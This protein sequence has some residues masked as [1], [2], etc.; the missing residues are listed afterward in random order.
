[1]QPAPVKTPLITMPHRTGGILVKDETAQTT[2]AFKFRGVSAKLLQD[3]GTGPV[4]TAS[5]GN[6]GAAVAAV[7]EVQGR[8]AVVFV[9]ADTPTAKTRRIEEACA[10]LIRYEGDY[11]ACAAA[12]QDWARNNGA[13]YIPSFDDPM[14]IAGHSSAFREILEATDDL[15]YAWLP[16]G[17]GG[18]L[19]AAVT[20]LPSRTRVIGVELE[21]ADAMRQSLAA[22]R[23]LT[24]DVPR[25]VAEGLCVRQVGALPFRIASLARVPIVTVSVEQLEQAVR[26]LWF[27]AGIRAELA[28]AAAL[29]AAH[30]YIDHLPG[31]HVTVVS[32]GN[33]DAP[34]FD[35]IVGTTQA[36][37]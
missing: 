15:D 20:T 5:T 3:S 22:G 35:R 32:G 28:G 13:T 9:P 37:A 10:I 34:V 26:D 17:G 24:V 14:I 23:R 1:M 25:G 4:C 27:S 2:G 19:S 7:A 36:A 8:Q 6:H 31:R 12:A 16:V 29:A 30:A 33:I 21:G 18:F 11:T